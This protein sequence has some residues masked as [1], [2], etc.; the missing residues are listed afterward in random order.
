MT[1]G[2]V[3]LKS[4]DATQK[5]IPYTLCFAFPA[6]DP[7]INALPRPDDV[8][9]IPSFRPVPSFPPY[10]PKRN[11][12]SYNTINN[13]NNKGGICGKKHPRREKK[14]T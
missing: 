5:M 6:S 4:I 1:K 7:F 14:P 8:E 3:Y 13:K 9:P 12:D 11:C 2:K 10:M